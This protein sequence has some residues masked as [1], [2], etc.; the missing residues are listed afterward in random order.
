MS[1]ENNTI[2][3]DLDDFCET[4]HSLDLLIDLKREIRQFQVTLFT[5]PGRSSL[6][7]L[8]VMKQYDW[9]DMAPHGWMHETSRECERWSYEE[10]LRYLDRI[11]HLELTRGFKAPGWQISDGAYLA[12]LERGYW[13]ADQ[14]YNNARRPA[15]LPVYLLDSPH[16]LHGHIGHLGGHNYNELSLILPDLLR[17]REKDFGFVRE[18]VG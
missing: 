15:D 9:I 2:Y 14:A 3:L 13:V 8:Q 18:A 16:K 11:E 10:T 12:L 5:I 6:A 1:P 4:N 7:W 17:H